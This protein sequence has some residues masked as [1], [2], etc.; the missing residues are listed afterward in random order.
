V[1]RRPRSS[2]GSRRACGGV[3]SVCFPALLALFLMDGAH[4]EQTDEKNEEPWKSKLTP[5]PEQRFPD[6]KPLEVEFEFGWADVVRAGSAEVVISIPSPGKYEV[7]GE[8]RSEGAVSLLWKLDATHKSEGTL[9]DF[10]SQ[11]V[12][13]VEKYRGKTLTTQLELDGQSVRRLLESTR[14]P[15]GHAKWKTYEEPE[16]RDLLG[17][18]L[19]IRS[20]PLAKGDKVYAIAYPTTNPFLVTVEVTD[21]EKIEV[22]GKKRDAIRLELKLQEILTKKENAGQLKD[23]DKFKGGRIWLSNDENRLPLRAE[24]DTFIGYVYGELTGVEWTKE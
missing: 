8:G 20:Q 12:R 21:Y 23:F 10:R 2:G 4:A 9:L 6:F 13:Q 17:A 14:D 19:L 7:L 11:R 1:K 5:V 16:A 22:Q 18:M 3:V 24:I 15:E